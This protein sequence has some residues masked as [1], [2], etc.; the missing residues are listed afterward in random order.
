MVSI[1]WGV[2]GVAFFMA[3]VDDE[4]AAL[5]LVALVA[6][7]LTVWQAVLIRRLYRGVPRTGRRA[8]IT[9]VILTL[10]ALFPPFDPLYIGLGLVVFT[11]VALA[12]VLVRSERQAAEPA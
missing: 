12:L 2:V 7:A 5:I 3:A 10:P 8:V 11:L 6:L 1:G 9:L 4:P